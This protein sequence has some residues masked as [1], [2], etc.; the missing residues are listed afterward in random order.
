MAELGVRTKRLLREYREIETCPVADITIMPLGGDNLTEWHGNIRGDADSTTW[1]NVVVHFKIVI[2]NTYPVMP[3]RVVLSSFF[4]HINVMLRNGAWEICLD[5]LEAPNV[6][7]PVTIKYKH[8]SSAYTIRSILV[9]MKSF[10]LTDHQPNTTQHGGAARV[11]TE[12]AAFRCPDCNHSV[13]SIIPSFCTPEKVLNAPVSYPLVQ[14]SAK[15][16]CRTGLLKTIDHMDSMDAKSAEATD[17]ESVSGSSADNSCTEDG[18]WINVGKRGGHVLL[19]SEST[20]A[21]QSAPHHLQCSVHSNK[22]AEHM[23]QYQPTQKS[24]TD[25]NSES[26]GGTF[27]KQKLEV[28]SCIKQTHE[29]LETAGG[30]WIEVV[31]KKHSYSNGLHDLYSTQTN[32]FGHLSLNIG[33]AMAAPSIVKN[34]TGTAVS[35]VVL[36]S[37]KDT[38]VV[39]MFTLIQDGADE[40]MKCDSCLVSRSKDYFS[41]TAWKN[42]NQNAK[43]IACCK[44]CQ[45]KRSNALASPLASTASASPALSSAA[46]KNFLKREK[47][48]RAA[49]QQTPD[50]SVSVESK[51][52]S[53][54]TL[55]ASGPLHLT[56]NNPDHVVPPEALQSA[57]EESAH[58]PSAIALTQKRPTASSAA[59][60]NSSCSN[61]N[62]R[63]SNSSGMGLTFLARDILI[64]CGLAVAPCGGSINGNYGICSYLD[65]VEVLHLSATCKTMKESMLDWWL[66][67]DLFLRRFPHSALRPSDSDDCMDETGKLMP[68]TQQ[69]NIAWKYAYLLEANR[70]ADDLQCFHTKATKAD[71]ILGFPIDYTINPKTNLLDYVTS[72]FDIISHSAYSFHG[73]RRAVWGEKFLAFLPLYI[74]QDHFDKS[75]SLLFSVGVRLMKSASEPQPQP[76]HQTFHGGSHMRHCRQGSHRSS[77]VHQSQQ[78]KL[79]LWTPKT[80]PELVLALL[81]KMMNT[82]VVLLCDNG[83][84][85]S[86]CALTGYCQLHR[87]MLAVSEKYPKLRQLADNRLAHFIKDPAMRTKQFTPSLGI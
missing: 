48:R 70:L 28:T 35:S 21:S 60:P 6:A 38:A 10:L 20:A 25:N 36:S 37:R 64:G 47:K 80:Q 13:T 57:K 77:E 27:N 75:C 45:Q 46:Q 67:R 81:V 16:A 15:V 19:H 50:Q 55:D 4:P 85:S 7:S 59:H 62:N 31:K 23:Q 1:S 22:V 12:A 69:L 49:L 74:D 79:D 78:R 52:T 11:L 8:W 33:S 53:T 3:P 40:K 2:P 76:Y 14:I 44:V 41:H 54:S 71:D 5:M 66:W 61:S 18:G 43:R 29:H 84:V 82:Q 51:E 26:S 87:L 86:D 34:Q 42:C 68:R 65:T 56:A 17:E 73:V 30:Q 24:K 39:N 63:S 83:I 9:Q 72:T 58:R 32:Q